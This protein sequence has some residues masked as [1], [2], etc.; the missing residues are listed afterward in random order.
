M[1]IL[2]KDC[3]VIFNPCH[4]YHTLLVYYHVQCSIAFLVLSV[5]MGG[6]VTS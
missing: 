1:A 3:H 2:A 6:I 4:F 5:D